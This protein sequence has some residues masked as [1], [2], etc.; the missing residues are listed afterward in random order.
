MAQGNRE[1]DAAGCGAK[2]TAPADGVGL[3]TFAKCVKDSERR[4]IGGLV[5][6]PASPLTHSHRS[7]HHIFTGNTRKP[8]NLLFASGAGLVWAR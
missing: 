7:K 4:R 5:P 2:S 8:K 3:V 6:A 1:I